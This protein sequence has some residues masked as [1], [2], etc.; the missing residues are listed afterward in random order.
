MKFSSTLVKHCCLS[1]KCFYNKEKASRLLVKS[2]LKNKV[3]F[4]F[5]HNCCFFLRKRLKSFFFA[6]TL[7]PDYFRFAS[8]YWSITLF[9]LR[10]NI[11][12][13]NQ[14]GN[15]YFKFYEVTHLCKNRCFRCFSTKKGKK[16]K[17]VNSLRNGEPLNA[18]AYNARYSKIYEIGNES[19]IY[20]Q[21]SGKS[22]SIYLSFCIKPCLVRAKAF[23]Y[24]KLK[25]F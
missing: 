9:F 16:Q 4:K 6:A 12:F 25:R 24:T 13:N 18:K 11:I 8:L 3:I 23:V 22:K 19:N 15:D 17:Q 20:Y 10:E 1:V 7:M 14:N 5:I 21:F 2:L